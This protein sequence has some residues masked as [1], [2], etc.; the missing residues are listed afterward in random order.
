MYV[1]TG[2]GI[3]IFIY[4]TLLLLPGKSIYHEDSEFVETSMKLN[5]SCN[6]SVL[7]LAVVYIT[8]SDI[9]VTFYS[10][11]LTRSSL[12]MM[13]DTHTTYTVFTLVQNFV[14]K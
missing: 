3:F 11:K 10:S 12:V 13:T 9:P 8:K 5:F 14:G 2:L 6:T 7:N 4:K 1:N